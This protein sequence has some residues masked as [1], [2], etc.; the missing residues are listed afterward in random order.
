MP[1]PPEV[2]TLLEIPLPKYKEV[3]PPPQLQDI[4]PSL[5][6]LQKLIP[7]LR[8]KALQRAASESER[9]YQ[10]A[11]EEWETKA[12]AIRQANEATR[13]AYARK[14]EDQL[15]SDECLAYAK[16]HDHWQQQSALLEHENDSAIAAWHAAKKK[17]EAADEKQRTP[18]VELRNRYLASDREAIEAVIR[19][20][21]EKSPYPQCFPR[22]IEV[23][24]NPENRI[25][26]INFKLPDFQRVQILTHD[27]KLG[28]RQKTQTQE[29]ALYSIAIRTLYEVIST[30]E[31]N[32]IDSIVFNG[33]VDYIDGATGQ[34]RQAYI[35]SV[36]AT[37]S[38]VADLN[39]AQLNP[40]ECFKSLKGLAAA[41]ISAYTPVAP[42]LTFD[43]H[44]D[45][46]VEGRKVIEGLSSG[47]N[48]AAMGWDDFEHLIRELFE[49]VFSA[50][51]VD[52]RITRA[53]RDRGVDAIIFDPD[54][55]RGGR[56]IIQAK[57]Y[58]NLVD[59]AAVRDLF[60]TVQAEKANRGIL[61]TTSH[62]GPDAHEF[63]KDKNIT[64]IEGPELL[65]L[66]EK[67]GYTFR[68]DLKEARKLLG[69]TPSD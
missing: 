6:F 38:Q 32:A 5:T 41:R 67:H 34:A 14:K 17:F 37:K 49:R 29:T 64:L 58:T 44:D 23:H 27:R 13:R 46:L 47:D 11:R 19:R 22:N 25:A 21:L 7:A 20:T 24:Y 12:A 66:F 50:P 35:L 60:G 59:V 28:D 40:L 4:V 51:G 42:L 36:H 30:D 52:V 43:K 9:R 63:A 57:K 10:L 45:R 48:L 39:I 1:A 3:P 33:W 69:L 61:V 62:F 8:E 31:I 26:L 53:S 56:Y 55:I 2:P 15:T 54:P 65:H 16:A 18:V 68:I